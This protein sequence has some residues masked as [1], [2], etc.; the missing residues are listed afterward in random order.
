MPRLPK[1]NFTDG[2]DT[3]EEEKPAYN[4]DAVYGLNIKKIAGNTPPIEYED[5]SIGIGG[6]RLYP[7]GLQVV[8]DLN[9]A[10]WVNALQGLQKIQR[11]Y[12]WMMAD[13][14]RYGLERN[15]GETAEQVERI[16]EITGYSSQALNDFA[17]MAGAY[18]ISSRKENLDM[19]HHKLCAGLSEEKREE[20]LSYAIEHKLS[21]AQLEAAMNGIKVVNPTPLDIFDKRFHSFRKSQIGLAKKMNRN[22]RAKMARELRQLADEIDKD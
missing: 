12:Q 8:G 17:W 1:D 3:P 14:L 9:E 10:N 7:T 6:L 15:Y 22:D 4:A 16:A 19:K 5:G 21:A 18:E 2:M 20:W 11:V 13:L